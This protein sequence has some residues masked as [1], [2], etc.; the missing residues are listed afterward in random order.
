MLSWHLKSSLFPRACSVASVVSD[1]LQPMDCTPS[2]SHVYG[3]LQAR[4]REWIAIFYYRGSSQ[5][6]DWTRLS[7]VS[8]IGRQA[9]YHYCHL[10][11]VPIIIEMPFQVHILYLG[12]IWLQE[13]WVW[14]LGREDSLEKEMVTCSS[15][16]AWEIPWTEKPG[17]LQSMGWQ[18]NRTQLN[19]WVYTY[20]WRNDKTVFYRGGLGIGKRC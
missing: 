5:P 19:D 4:I 13:N 2:G 17:G 18:K 16:L 1:S 15:I 3:I 8:W 11:S 14:S 9:L 6:R 10:S 7:Y 12:L 20:T